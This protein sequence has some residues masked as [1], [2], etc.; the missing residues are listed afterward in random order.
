MHRL[1]TSRCGATLRGV[2]AS[3]AATFAHVEAY[4]RH[5]G[6]YG[7]A[8]ARALVE[9][10]GVRP[11]QAALDVG[12]GPGALT[13]VLGQVLGAANVAA[14]DPSE[15]FASACRQRVPGADVRVATAEALPDFGRR[16]D[17]VLSQ[18]VVNFLSDPRAGVRA[19]RAAARP[20]GTVAS[21]VWDYADGMTLLRAFWDAALEVDPAAPD[22]GRTMQWCSPDE[23]RRLWSECGLG[24]VA[25]GSLTV[26]AAYASFEDLW[27]PFTLGIAPS[28]A[29]CASLDR[30][31]REALRDAF[32]ARLGSPG[33][34]FSLAA[35]AWFVRGTP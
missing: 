24:A 30:D 33:G 9:T 16:F 6:R 13:S 2:E 15:P 28:G 32:F 20:G 8:L 17:A 34:A 19:M 21:C 11:G 1:T 31:R 5:V 3:G 14:V 10:A 12:C 18:L 25:T 29:F 35:C 4:D 23:L 26:A 22:E 7:D 27:E